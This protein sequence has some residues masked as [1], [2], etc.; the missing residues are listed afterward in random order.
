M[1]N[2]ELLLALMGKISCKCPFFGDHRNH[3]PVNQVTQALHIL[4]DRYHSIDFI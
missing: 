2:E 3:I 4:Y 1:I